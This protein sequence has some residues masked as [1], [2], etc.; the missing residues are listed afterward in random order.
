VCWIDEFC[1]N[2]RNQ[3]THRWSAALYNIATAISLIAFQLNGE[4]MKLVATIVASMF[5]AT[6]AMAQA[7]AKKEEVKP[8]APAAAPAKKE[9]KKAEAKPAAPAKKEEKKAEA[10]K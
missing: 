8:A 4:V 3:S 7:P 9:E 5:A 2:R 10:K 1:Q 6:A